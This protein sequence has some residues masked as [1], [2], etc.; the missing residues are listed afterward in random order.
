MRHSP[1]FP[2]PSGP[3]ASPQDSE[4]E[5]RS[6]LGHRPAALIEVSV[7]A[8]TVEEFPRGLHSATRAT[9]VS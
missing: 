4:R 7:V 3:P 9:A 2:L 1:G 8:A 6:H 5:P